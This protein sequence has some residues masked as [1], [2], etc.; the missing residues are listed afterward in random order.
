MRYKT[1]VTTEICEL[2]IASLIIPMRAIMVNWS[3]VAW[4]GGPG[5]DGTVLSHS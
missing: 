3:L 1:S 5:G 2:F 4:Q